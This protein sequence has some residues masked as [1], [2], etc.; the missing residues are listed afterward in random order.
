MGSV[1]K[2]IRMCEEY[3]EYQWQ[4]P[5]VETDQSANSPSESLPVERRNPFENPF[6]DPTIQG[7]AEF[8]WCWDLGSEVNAGRNGCN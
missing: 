8:S 5:C 3:G 7:F 6:P 2:E 4:T 1:Y